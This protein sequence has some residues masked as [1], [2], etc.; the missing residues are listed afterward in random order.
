[1]LS[2]ERV[3]VVAKVPYAAKRAGAVY[4]LPVAERSQ[5]VKALN[6]LVVPSIYVGTKFCHLVLCSSAGPPPHFLGF[7]TRPRWSWRLSRVALD[8]SD[9]RPHIEGTVQATVLGT[10]QAT[11]RLRNGVEQLFPLGIK[12]EEHGERSH[13]RW[14]V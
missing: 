8:R 4:L 6:F 5:T 13:R 7:G 3:Q 9:R 10:V 12:Q 1:M 14:F 2:E 11:G